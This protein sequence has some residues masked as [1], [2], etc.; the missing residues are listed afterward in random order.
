LRRAVALR[1]D[2]GGDRAPV[3]VSSG[4][5][6]LANRLERAALG[7]G[8]PVVRDVPLAE[9]LAELRAGDE[10]PEA[11]YGAVAAILNELAGGLGHGGVSHATA[12]APRR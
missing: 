9:A 5:G 4:H 2:D 8:V 11:L 3:V 12:D 6:A 7:Y 10:I 1:Y